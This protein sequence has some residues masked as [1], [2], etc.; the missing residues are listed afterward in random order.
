MLLVPFI[1]EGLSFYRH[2]ICRQCLQLMRKAQLDIGT[3]KF[4]TTKHYAEY[5]FLIPC[6]ELL[7]DENSN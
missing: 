1:S 7:L 2:D 5:T 4:F 6:D 3:V